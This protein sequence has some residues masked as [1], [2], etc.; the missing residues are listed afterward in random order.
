MTYLYSFLIVS[1]CTDNTM[2]K[3]YLQEENFSFSLHFAVQLREVTVGI[4][5]R[6]LEAG[7]EAETVGNPAYWLAQLAF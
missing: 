3:S 1:C 2:T 6:N 5:G 4:Q 7:N